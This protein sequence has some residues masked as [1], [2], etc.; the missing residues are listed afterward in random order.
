[1]KIKHLFLA[2]SLLT[3]VC[4]SSPK[5]SSSSFGNHN[6]FPPSVPKP[7]DDGLSFE[8]AIVITET[9]DMQGTDAEYK[10]IR[11][12]YSNYK[13]K[14]QSLNMHNKKPY[15]I[16]TIVLSDDKELPLYFDISNSY[17]KF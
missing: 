12:H 8:T 7:T 14:G 4:C 10:W 17:G 2:A 1:M 13:I 11:N 9:N 6:S 3:V 15:D 5:K 16:I